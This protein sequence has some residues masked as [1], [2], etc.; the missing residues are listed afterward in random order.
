MKLLPLTTKKRSHAFSD[1]S[2]YLDEEVV[3][4]DELAEEERHT[5]CLLANIICGA[6]FLLLSLV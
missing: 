4:F 3:S 2:D 1:I 6:I 5:C